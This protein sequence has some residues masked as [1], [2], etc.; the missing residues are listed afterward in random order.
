MTGLET[1]LSLVWDAFVA[2]PGEDVPLDVVELF[3]MVSWRPA[4]LAG[5][6]W[7]HGHGGP[8]APGG[9]GH[10]CVFDPTAAWTVDRRATASRSQNSPYDGMRLSGRVRHTVLAGDPVVVDGR[11]QR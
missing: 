9:H 1:A 10:L 4:A 2:G 11:A 3:A 6:D 8:I 7:S 5:L